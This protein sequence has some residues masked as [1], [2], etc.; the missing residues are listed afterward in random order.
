[1]NAYKQIKDY[2]KTVPELYKYIPIGIAAEQTAMYFPIVPWAEDIKANQWKEG[3]KDTIDSI[4]PL[5]C[6][7]RTYYWISSAISC[8]SG[9]RWEMLRRS[10]QGTCSTGQPGKS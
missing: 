9:W 10:S 2:E 8:S 3:E 6:S 7:Q 5:R 1:M 4:P